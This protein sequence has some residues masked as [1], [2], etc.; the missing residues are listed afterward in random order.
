MSGVER[1]RS[2]FVLGKSLR[3][4]PTTAARIRDRIAREGAV[5]PVVDR[6]GWTV[7]ERARV[8][9]TPLRVEDVQLLLAADLFKEE[10]VALAAV[11]ELDRRR[12]GVLHVGGRYGVID[13]ESLRRYVELIKLG[14]VADGVVELGWQ[15]MPMSEAAMA[16]WRT[17]EITESALSWVATCRSLVASDE[18]AAVDGRF[19]VEEVP[20]LRYG[21]SV[22]RRRWHVS[23]LDVVSIGVA[24]KVRELLGSS[25]VLLGTYCYMPVASGARISGTRTRFAPVVVRFDE[26][27]SR[28]VLSHLRGVADTD[29]VRLFDEWSQD[30]RRAPERLFPVVVATGPVPAGFRAPN[31]EWGVARQPV[32]LEVDVAGGRVGVFG[33]RLPAWAPALATAVAE[34]GAGLLEL[35]DRYRV[36]RISTAEPRAAGRWTSD[37]AGVWSSGEEG[38]DG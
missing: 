28:I 34:L 15:T 18:L 33:R 13:R 7:G 25:A 14:E 4:T 36:E 16:Y 27:R 19:S 26:D 29:F 5:V 35:S 22:A 1:L 3:L 8:E 12:G 21:A 38:C 31:D 37:D 24:A 11:L 20:H 9:R 30:W 10:R 6:T 17:A 23:D 32:S 2:A